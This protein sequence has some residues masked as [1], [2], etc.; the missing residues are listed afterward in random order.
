MS[1]IIIKIKNSLPL[2]ILLLL[3]V[4]GFYR[5]PYLISDSSLIVSIKRGL[6]FIILV[7]MAASIDWYKV[8]LNCIFWSFLSWIIINITNFVIVVNSTYASVVTRV[9]QGVFAYVLIL[10]ISQ[11]FRGKKIVNLIKKI[12]PLMISLV[13]FFILVMAYI[14]DEWRLNVY[15]GFGGNRVNFSIWIAQFTFLL[16]VYFLVAEGK[17]SIH[18]KENKIIWKIWFK[19]LIYVAPL[20]F[21]QVST[22]SRLGVIVSV[23]LLC[24]YGSL[25]FRSLK[26]LIV[27][28]MFCA[29]I[30][31]LSIEFSLLSNTSSFYRG[32][33]IPDSNLVGSLDLNLFN[34]SLYKWVDQASSLRLSIFIS[35]IYEI[36]SK[37]F[38]FGVGIGNFIGVSSVG[39]YWAIHNVLLNSLGEL[40]FLG[41]ISFS[42]IMIMPFLTKSRNSLDYFI[43]FFCL[44]WVTISMLQPDFL[45]TQISTSIVY[46]IAYAY[47]C[48]DRLCK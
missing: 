1:N 18:F 24:C 9:V 23:A 47:L 40:G 25:N 3:C 27:A 17:E 31:K 19:P 32:I 46:F 2:L 15:D 41:I 30:L 44:L 28:A 29:V 7:G 38:I 4:S 16:I 48:R 42:I 34:N 39:D 35:G 5:V 10:Y 6:F 37:I 13:A 22:T 8:Q 11:F 36:T 33:S 26:G 45:I 20:L 14:D 21:L 43:K 12:K